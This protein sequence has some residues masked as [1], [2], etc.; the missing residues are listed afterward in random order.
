MA[1]LRRSLIIN[2]LS[3]SGATFLQFVVSVLLARILSPSEIGIYSMTVVFVNLAHVFRDFGVNSY[4]QR[5]DNLTPDKIRSATGVVFTSSWLIATALFLASGWLGRW[6]NEPGIVPVMRVLAIGFFFIPFGAITSALLSR[7]FAAEKQAIVN[8]VGTTSFCVSCLV[9]AK[10]GFGSMALAWA[11]LINILACA[12][13]YIPLRPKNLPWSPSFKH[14]RSVAHFGLGSLLSSCAGSLNNAIPDILLG[15]L[16]TAR[17][18]GLLSRANS[19]VT[20]FTYV[21]GSTVSYGAVSYLAQ[22]HHR[23]ESLVPVLSR[24]TVLLTGVGWAAL[25]LTAVLGQDIVAALYGPKWGECVPAILPLAIAAAVGMMFHYIPM[26]VTAIG[27]PYL[28]AV[29]TMIT[30]VSRIGFG[31]LLF[32]GS[33]VNFA[34]ALCLAT[35]ATAPSVLMQ[36]KRHF[37]FTAG[38]LLRAV[39]P[40]AIVALGTAAAAAALAALLPDTLAPMT[41]LLIMAVPLAAVW[42]LLLRATRHELVGEIHRLGPPIKARLMLLRP[43]V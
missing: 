33:L 1:D 37:G 26:A 3:S 36:Q 43:N 30:L 19:T 18:V 34:W 8:A 35:V 22:S 38:I 21:A 28:S 42:Y 40:S 20:I 7:E 27:R 41:R 2:F 6:F 4:L 14:W 13:A 25:A 15:K 17:H 11:N 23:G 5:E 10:L 32:D 16:G 31:V 39:A 12:L 24:A 9:L 29:P